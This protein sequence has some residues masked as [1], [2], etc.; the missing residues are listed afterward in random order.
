VSDLTTWLATCVGASLA[1][2]A[3]EPVPVVTV[4]SQSPP[5]GFWDELAITFAKVTGGIC[6]C[7]CASLDRLPL[8]LETGCDV[9]PADSVFW[10]E[11]DTQ[12]AI[13]YGGD[14]KVMMCFDRKALDSSWREVPADTD[15]AELERLAAKFPTKRVSEDSS[16]L[17][18]SRLPASDPRVASPY[19]VAYGYWIPGDPFQALKV[20]IVIGSDVPRLSARARAMLAACEKPRWE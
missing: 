6:W 2:L 4:D 7:R 11:M 5:E 12:K 15:P 14:E 9:Q 16:S 17:W 1:L 19:E 13:E 8:I 10:A 18:F 20:L 3:K